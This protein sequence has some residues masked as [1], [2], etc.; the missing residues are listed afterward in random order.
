MQDMQQVQ[1]APSQA[2]SSIPSSPAA[3]CRLSLLRFPGYHTGC[4]TGFLRSGHENQRIGPGG[5][6]RRFRCGQGRQGKPSGPRDADGPGPFGSNPNERWPG[7]N[8]DGTQS[9][10]GPVQIRYNH[11][12]RR[13]SLKEAQVLAQKGLKFDELSP[14]LDKLRYLAAANNKSLPDM[15]DALAQSQDQQLYRSLMQECGGNEALAKRLYQAEKDKWNARFA[16]PNSRM[17]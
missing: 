13:I 15:V 11:E 6:R 4:R 14:T 16:T 8:G 10:Q 9:F 12:T 2:V 17:P 3:D 7:Q 5:I 1:A